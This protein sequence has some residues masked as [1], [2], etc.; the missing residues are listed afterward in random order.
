MTDTITS[1]GPLERTDGRWV[2]GDVRRTDGFWAEF[3]EDGLHQH[4]PGT[5]GQ[6]I[7]WSRIML[8]V[9]LTLG[10]KYPYQGHGFGLSDILPGP[11]KGRDSG[12]LHMTLRHP[13]EDRI[14]R[15]SCHPQSYRATDV[16]LLEALLTQAVQEQEVH[17][18]ADADRVGRM[19]AH[20]APLRARTTGAVRRAV[21]EAWQAAA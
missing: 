15:F 11:R 7:P 6:L 12:Y 18:L 5:D 16:L 2:L 14:L 4:E 13:Y 19:V 21:T 10:T 20:L 17:R 3:R 9:R 8:G 1:L